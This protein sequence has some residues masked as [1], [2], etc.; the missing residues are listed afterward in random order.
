MSNRLQRCGVPRSPGTWRGH[1]FWSSFS[2]HFLTFNI[3]ALFSR[4]LLLSVGAGTFHR[5]SSSSEEAVVVPHA[6]TSTFCSRRLMPSS[7]STHRCSVSRTSDQTPWRSC[8]GRT[9]CRRRRQL[10]RIRVGRRR[11]EAQGRILK[12]VKAFRISQNVYNLI[13]TSRSSFSARYYSICNVQG[14]A[15]A[16]QH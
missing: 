11:K 10:K 7:R 16:D 5:L 2:V 12:P 14:S 3:L 4:S 8:S 13:T 9:R 1:H 6:S 15:S